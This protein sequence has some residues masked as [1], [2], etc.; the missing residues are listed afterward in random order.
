MIFALFLTFLRQGSLV[1]F[2]TTSFSADL[3][4]Q[5]ALRFHLPWTKTTRNAGADVTAM[6]HQT[7][8]PVW[9]MKN[10]LRVNASAPSFSHL[11]SY[12]RDGE[13]VP[14]SKD[15][16]MTRAKEIWARSSLQDVTG[17]S[18]RIGGA[19][20]LLLA[21]IPAKVVATIGRWKSL[22]FL[23]YWRRHEDIVGRAFAKHY[24][25]SRIRALN[26]SVSRFQDDCGIDSEFLLEATS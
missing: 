1:Q 10:H 2:I 12:Q 3:P 22:A 11:F 20:E 4:Q 18:F 7:L 9:A 26:A 23:L 21:G 5:E 25:S 24:D 16:F 14:L 19:T 13:W 15:V 8:S 6:G 17:H